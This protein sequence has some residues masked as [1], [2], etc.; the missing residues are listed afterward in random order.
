MFDLDEEHTSFN[1][2]RGLYCY[3]VMLFDLK[4]AGA[5]N[6]RLVKA[7]FKDLIRKTMEVY[8]DDLL[9]KSRIAKD[10]MD[11]LEERFS[12]LRKY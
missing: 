7:M 1:T 3:N 8:V 5:T 4:N 9:V 6:Q 12:I 10:H 2:D 11:H